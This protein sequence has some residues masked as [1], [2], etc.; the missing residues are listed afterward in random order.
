MEETKYNIELMKN[1][2]VV[3]QQQQH[4]DQQQQMLQESHEMI[5]QK[6]IPLAPMPTDNQLLGH[7]MPEMMNILD[8]TDAKYDPSL[9]VAGFY[10]K[11]KNIV[12]TN[13]RK[14]GHKFGEDEL[15]QDEILSPT[16][17]EV[18][19]VLCLDKIQPNLSQKLKP[20]YSDRLNK[21]SCLIELKDEVFQYISK[22][23]LSD[24]PGKCKNCKCHKV[25]TKL[26]EVVKAEPEQYDEGTGQL[27][28]LNINGMMNI[29]AEMLMS[30]L[31]QEQGEN[32]EDYG[33]YDDDYEDEDYDP[34]YMERDDEGEEDMDFKPIKEPRKPRKQRAKETKQR[35]K[36]E[37]ELDADGLPIKQRRAKRY[38]NINKYNTPTPCDIC[39]KTCAGPRRL[40]EHMARKHDPTN[41]KRDKPKSMK[42]PRT[43]WTCKHCDLVFPT[44]EEIKK[45]R[46][47]NHAP[48]MMMELCLFCGKNINK[49]SMKRHMLT[50][51]SDISCSIC[52][53]KFVTTNELDMHMKKHEENPNFR[54]TRKKNIKC[55]ICG[56]CFL[57]P[58]DYGVHICKH[59]SCDTCDASFL[60]RRNLEVHKRAHAGEQIYS[61]D[62]C[63]A[64]FTKRK[65][66]Y[67]HKRA[68]HEMDKRKYK[69]DV[70]GL[71]FLNPCKVEKH[72]LIHTNEKPVKCAQCPKSFKDK[73]RLKHHIAYHHTKE[74]PH[75]PCISC[76]RMFRDS[77][78]MKIHRES[79]ECDMK[80]ELHASGIS[81][82]LPLPL[83]PTKV[84]S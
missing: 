77:S 4:H 40:A 2:D 38:S 10:E 82:P 50:H 80:K 48:H 20:V 60:K 27:E 43:K 46:A 16:F 37:P 72:K 75:I 53:E 1:V 73:E 66:L 3:Q 23:N 13:L 74:A 6:S 5:E 8:L 64:L 56:R 21:G 68:T 62:I 32:G 31:D 84:E 35:V 67:C 45:H 11:M 9:G 59:F 57:N 17:E 25:Q 52:Y 39:G 15:I 54:P 47:E 81:H 71:M 76:D 51:T 41:P 14:R 30:L 55:D 49:Y 78:Q 26:E 19:I 33:D 65:A 44:H 22:E 34:N 18:L 58:Q 29:P 70:C 83:V 79:G 42:P 69:C 36:K 61:C 28:N 7:G 24:D 63:E 12:L